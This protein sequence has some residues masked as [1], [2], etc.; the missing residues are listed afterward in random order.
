VA[1]EFIGHGVFGWLRKPAWIPYFGVAGIGPD[2]ARTLMPLVGWHDMVLGVIGLISPRPIVLAWMSFW[3]LWTAL[4]RPLSGEPFWETLE[5]AGNIGVPLA[6]L[7]YTWP[8]ARGIGAWFAPARPSLDNATRARMAVILRWTTALLLIGHGALGAL[9]HKPMLVRHAALIGG[10][11][12]A[13]GIAEIAMGL[14][15]LVR[16]WPMLLAFACAWKLATESLFLMAG[17]PVWEFIERGGSYAAPLA[18]MWLTARSKVR[19]VAPGG[20]ASVPRSD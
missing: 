12:S 15:I 2:T 7:V 18:L 17:A 9:V 5:R 1:A 11:A 14:A 4:L 16:P 20:S 19:S 10:S 8:A 3:G 6:F 13:F